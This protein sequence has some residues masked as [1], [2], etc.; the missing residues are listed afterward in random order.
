[1]WKLCNYLEI[2]LIERVH[3]SWEG[4]VYKGITACAELESAVHLVTL[5]NLYIFSSESESDAEPYL[6]PGVELPP[7]VAAASRQ[8][9]LYR[10]SKSPP[11]KS[12]TKSKQQS[13]KERE[14]RQENVE[15]V[16]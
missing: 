16:S 14:S 9:W 4:S 3:W 8:S 1:M 6:D 11:A 12:G 10:N 5:C 15:R 2:A 7:E 13:F